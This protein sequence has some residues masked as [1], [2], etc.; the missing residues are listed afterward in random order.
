MALWCLRHGL[1][2]KK[3]QAIY[4]SSVFSLAL[5]GS[6]RGGDWLPCTLVASWLGWNLASMVALPLL[7]P[8]G[9]TTQ[10]VWL[11][12]GHLVSG[13]MQLWMPDYMLSL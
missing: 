10:H 8:L 2:S 5:T 1:Q 9:A 4:F 3:W 12:P 6:A 11:V 7:L 13:F